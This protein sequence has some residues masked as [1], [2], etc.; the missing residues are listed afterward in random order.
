MLEQKLGTTPKAM[1][2]V[3]GA[4]PCSRIALQPGMHSPWVSRA[5]SGLGMR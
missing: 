3:F 1:K 4:I 2:E 5:L